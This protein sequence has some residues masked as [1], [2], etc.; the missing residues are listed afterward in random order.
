MKK[1]ILALS[2]F[3]AVFLLHGCFFLPPQQNSGPSVT[4]LINKVQPALVRIRSTNPEAAFLQALAD[5]LG[6]E[7]PRGLRGIGAVSGSGFLVDPSGIVVTNHHVIRPGWVTEVILADG[8]IFFAK[9][10]GGLE[11]NDIA[12]IVLRGVTDDLPYVKWAKEIVKKG[13]PI[14][15]LGRNTQFD[16]AYKTGVVSH[17]AR[18]QLDGSL[19][20]HTT[21]PVVPGESGSAAFN[22][23]GRVIGVV[24]SYYNRING[25][26]VCVPGPLAEDLVADIVVA[27]K[28]E[29]RKAERSEE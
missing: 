12:V 2:V 24:S 6:V 23:N 5:R 15:M 16:F 25:V 18:L 14:F 26:S 8:R 17:P 3:L 9:A 22:F 21:M 1:R 11:L 13:D 27:I 10:M 20:L 29:L 4:H 28:K 19:Q 7:V